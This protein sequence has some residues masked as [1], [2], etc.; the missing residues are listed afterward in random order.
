MKKRLFSRAFGIWLLAAGFFFAEYF[1]RVSPSVMVPQLMHA[2]QVNALS[3]GVLTSFF[4][5]AYVGMQLPVGVLI[6]RYGAHRLLTTMAAFCGLACFIFAASNSLWVASLARFIM[7][8]AAAFAFIGALS[9]ARTWFSPSK[10]GLLAG[11]TQ[12]LGMLGAAVG[13]A[14]VSILVTHLGYRF[15]IM[16]IGTILLLLALLMGLFVR[17]KPKQLAGNITPKNTAPKIG[18]LK[19]LQSVLA[20]KQCWVNGVFVGFLYAPTAAFAELWG[21]SYLHTIYVVPETIAAGMVGLI[22]VGF[23]AASPCAGW[24]SDKIKKRKPIMITSAVFSFIFLS[25]V[26]YAPHLRTW[27]AGILLFLYGASNVAVATSYAVASEIVPD[28]VSATSMSFANMA[29]V[30]IGA[31]FQPVIGELLVLG[32]HHTLSHGTPVYSAHDY[33]VAMLSLPLCLLISIA[34]SFFIKESY[35]NSCPST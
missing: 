16:T 19:S 21:S 27:E 11:A 24:L 10:F 9:L 18:L 26:L 14:P 29:S 8:F 34:S 12:A 17:D 22:F 30:I 33:K 23:A 15:A 35:S 2:F 25:I 28:A 6:D 20:T 4:Y 5:Y 3:L 7:G 32:W 31:L 13:E 1:A